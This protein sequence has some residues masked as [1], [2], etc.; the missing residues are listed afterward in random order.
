MRRATRRIGGFAPTELARRFIED[1]SF[2]VY[3]LWV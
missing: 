2:R 1:E 3:R